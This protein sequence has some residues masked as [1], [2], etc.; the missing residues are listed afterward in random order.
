MIGRISW[1]WR[2]QCGSVSIEYGMIAILISLGI[3]GVSQLI[4]LD[5]A[6]IFADAQ[7][8]LANR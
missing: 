6:S 4:A 5:L 2:D 1:F 3:I 8:G 7:A